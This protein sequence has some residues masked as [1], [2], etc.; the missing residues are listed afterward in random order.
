MA[1]SGKVL[2]LIIFTMTLGAVQFWANGAQAQ[3]SYFTSRG[4]SGCHAAPVATTCKGCHHHGA[5]PLAGAT[6]KTTYS[7]GE[8]VTVTIT[9]GSRTG[10]F[11]A[12]LRDQ[13]GAQLAV[14][15]GNESGMG[16][17]TTSPATLSAPAPTTPGTY[18]WKAAWF[19]N[20]AN[21]G[22]THGEVSVNTNSFTVS[23]PVPSDTTPPALTVSTLANGATTTNATLNVSG[24][25]SDAGG[26]ASVTV[27]GAAVTVTS[28]AFST[29]LTLVSGANTITTI[30]SD[31]AGNKTTDTR[32]ITYNPNIL[33]L[34]IATPADNSKINK[35]FVDVTGSVSEAATVTV[36]GASASM[37]GL[38]FS[39]TVNLAAG[40]N[41]INVVATDQLNNTASAKRTITS[42][43]TAPTVAVTD[44]AQDITTSL[45]SVT[46]AGTVTDALTAVTITITADGMTYTPVVTNGSFSQTIALTTAMT[47]AVTVTATDEAGN[48]TSVSRNII[49]QRVSSGDVNGD[50][51]VDITDALM[52]LKIAVGLM[53]MDP[54]YLTQGDVAP[55]VNGKVQPDGK[56]DISDALNVLKSSVGLVT[57]L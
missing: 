44:P 52:E 55:V 13:N 36:N 43:T 46:I 32:T 27:N 19:G 37:N 10:W 30:A 39:S 9:A 57:P 18:T 49:S 54:G 6:N 23:A 8:T 20:T 41:T 56:I 53:P 21:T 24:T 38:N 51:R 17:S 40:A 22:S 31:N 29:A 11:R 5:S 4:C 25:V 1:F 28:G 2:A 42:D 45:G 15:S 34:T 47:Y 35:T 48:Q 12:I 33:A 3:S 14:S 50:G 16:Q 7:P 26:I